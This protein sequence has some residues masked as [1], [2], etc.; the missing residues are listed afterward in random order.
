M[1]KSFIPL[2]PTVKMSFYFRNNS[3]TAP[4][5]APLNWKARKPAK[6]TTVPVP[7][8]DSTTAF[9]TLSATAK[10]N[11]TATW[12]KLRSTPPPPQAKQTQSK[13]KSLGHF[14][15]RE[16]HQSIE[17]KNFNRL[18][19]NAIANNSDDDSDFEY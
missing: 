4:A 5:K 11:Q 15:K 3:T 7:V 19:L 6:A 10:K 12:E 8:L 14:Q 2:T 18:L 17:P 16:S 1:T 13:K 9:P